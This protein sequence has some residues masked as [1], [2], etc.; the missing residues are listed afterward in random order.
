MA[1]SS[2]LRVGEYA[3]A[4]SP[5]ASPATTGSTPLASSAAQT[6][7]PRPAYIER[8]RIRSAV[9]TSS[10]PNTA[11]AMHSGTTLIRSL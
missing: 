11:I 4:D 7:I 9:A 5:I 10:R 3:D 6:T 8:C 1:S 2:S